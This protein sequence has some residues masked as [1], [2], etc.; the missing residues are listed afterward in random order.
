M[1]II[2]DVSD[3]IKNIIEEQKRIGLLDQDEQTQVLEK[4]SRF[5][6]GDIHNGL[7]EI[8]LL[9][10]QEQQ[11]AQGIFEQEIENLF[12]CYENIL[13]AIYLGFYTAN[14][15]DIKGWGVCG[16]LDDRSLLF[17]KLNKK[18]L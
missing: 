16:L 1:V 15:S 17:S 5:I 9:K 4:I 10:K 2:I 13:R 8:Y 6:Y 18:D 11:I 3:D 12:C 14:I 7:R